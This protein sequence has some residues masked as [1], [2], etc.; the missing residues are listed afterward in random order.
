MNEPPATTTTDPTAL[1]P[2]GLVEFPHPA[3]RRPA[4]PLLR[5]DDAVREAVER[6]FEIM[7]EAEGIGLAANQVA[8][9]YRMF[10]VNC[11][12][13]QGQGEEHVFINPVLSRP[14]GTAVQEEGCLSL[15]G[16]RM[17]VRRP[18]RIVVEAWSL[19]GEPIKLDLDGL[20]ARVVQHEFDHLE[21]RLFTDRLPEAAALEVR[22]QLEGLAQ[23]F[24]GKQSRGELPPDATLVAELDRLEAARCRA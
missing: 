1:G 16:V 9:P 15:P 10:V 4:K 20:F 8:L 11:T 13:R 23:V 5:L 7:Y 18:E 12:G 3:L 6:M 14:R 2:L 17:D 22:S 19:A 21:G 24:A